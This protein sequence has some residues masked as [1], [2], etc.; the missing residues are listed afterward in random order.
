MRYYSL[1][2]VLMLNKALRIYRKK[3]GISLTENL[4]NVG[5]CCVLL[6]RSGQLITARTIQDK[7][8]KVNRAR[9]KNETLY[10]CINFFE[11]SGCL[12]FVIAKRR[13]FI[14]KIYSVNHQLILLLNDFEQTLRKAR[15]DY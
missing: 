14:S 11:N 9:M 2:N 4:L 7:L 10:K 8:C 15:H 6:H 13:G 3:K 12:N 5:Y 1:D